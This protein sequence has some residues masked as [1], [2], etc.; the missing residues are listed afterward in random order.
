LTFFWAL[1]I[2]LRLVYL[3]VVKHDDYVEIARSQHEQVVAVRA[4]RGEILD[5]TGRHPL[6]LS[7]QTRSVVINPQRVVNPRF[8]RWL[9][10]S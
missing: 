9:D 6:A 8:S 3:Q 5:R 4:T 10:P 2:I 7:I 1:A